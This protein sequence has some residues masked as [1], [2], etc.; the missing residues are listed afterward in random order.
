MP[1]WK[2][3]GLGSA[4]SRVVRLAASSASVFKVN[5]PNIFEGA[6]EFVL[7][8]SKPSDMDKSCIQFLVKSLQKMNPN[9]QFSDDEESEH[10]EDDKSEDSE[11]EAPDDDWFDDEDSDTNEFGKKCLVR[12]AYLWR[13]HEKQII[14]AGEDKVAQAIR[15]FNHSF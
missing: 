12:L 15:K 1:S 14:S 8:N 4:H 13:A 7:K 11:Y 3:P 2:D 5:H 6:A 9:S 10:S